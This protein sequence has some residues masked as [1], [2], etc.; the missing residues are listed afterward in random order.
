[1]LSIP[2]R[3]TARPVFMMKMFTMM[4]LQYNKQRY[5]FFPGLLKMTFDDALQLFS[6]GSIDLLHIDGLHTYE[7]VRHDFETWLPKMSD[8]GVILFH[9]INVRHDDFGVFRFWEE[10]SVR[11]PH[12]AFDHSNGLGV[13]AAGKKIAPLPAM[14]INVFGSEGGALHIKT[15]YSSLGHILV[16]EWRKENLDYHAAEPHAIHR[17]HEAT[18]SGQSR[19]PPACHR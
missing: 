13:L 9:D 3:G 12:L 19:K 5:H 15:L 1:M 7:A 17:F 6:N 4:S 8:S 11:Y 14:I 16:L 10:V 2:G 18:T